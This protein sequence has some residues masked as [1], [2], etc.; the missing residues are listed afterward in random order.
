MHL[1][2]SVYESRFGT[3]LVEIV[4]IGITTIRSK[5][6]QTLIQSLIWNPDSLDQTL[7]PETRI[8]GPEFQSKIQNQSEIQIQ[9]FRN[10][11]I[12]IRFSEFQKPETF[13]TNNFKN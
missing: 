13:R 11:E 1:F 8:S 2:D 3:L 5:S 6:F 7:N 12:Q 9:K 4:Q 10:L